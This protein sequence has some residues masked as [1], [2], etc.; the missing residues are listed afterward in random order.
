CMDRDRDRQKRREKKK[1]GVA[2]VGG[3]VL[4]Y[5]FEWE[6]EEDTGALPFGAMMVK[7]NTTDDVDDVELR[8]VKDWRSKSR[9]QMTARDW[10]A[11]LEQ[12]QIVFAGKRGVLPARSWSEMN[13]P[14]ALR[15]AVTDKGFETPFAVQMACIPAVISGHDMIGIAQ[16][17]S[18]KTVA[19]MFPIIARMHHLQV[20]A[21]G[22]PY[23]LVLAPTRLLVEQLLQ[24]SQ[25]FCER[26]QLTAVS[27]YGGVPIQPQILRLQKGCHILVATPGRLL[28]ILRTGGVSSTLRN[29]HWV[30]MDEA[31]KMID[32]GFE[33]QVQDCLSYIPTDTPDKV[34]V[35]MIGEQGE[36]IANQ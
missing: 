11:F 22:G 1:K 33:E 2:R 8:M 29:V 32:L 10:R 6:E 13:L 26:A 25:Y 14:S 28:D 17:G 31:D 27:V 19:F 20:P 30:V 4:E 34:D 18:G 5:N 15:L 16:T 3:R 21:I 7:A 12:H 36:T 23:C 35:Q 24:E 9:D